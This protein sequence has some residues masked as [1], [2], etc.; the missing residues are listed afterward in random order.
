VG[1]EIRVEFGVG[2][3]ILAEESKEN[4][5]S[6]FEPRFEFGISRKRDKNFSLRTTSV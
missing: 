2:S 3:L 6:V 1:K 5:M 4:T